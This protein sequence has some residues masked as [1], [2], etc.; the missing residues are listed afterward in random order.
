M[1][2]AGWPASSTSLIHLHPQRFN[3]V[4]HAAFSR[5]P[6]P[7]IA[8][9]VVV[10]AVTGGC[11]DP[12]LRL[13]AVYRVGPRP[14]ADLAHLADRADQRLVWR[15]RTAGQSPADSALRAGPGGGVPGTNL[16]HRRR[17]PVVAWRPGRQ[18]VGG[19]HHRHAKSLGTGAHPAHRHAGWC[20]VG[21]ADGV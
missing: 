19:E 6:W 1:S 2:V 12:G 8:P 3:G 15:F 7:A 13:I 21:R 11:A 18:C 16:E 14:V 20:G 10:L 5:T 17:R 4:P 9:D